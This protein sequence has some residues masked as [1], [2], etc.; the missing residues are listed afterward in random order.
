M[1]PAKGWIASM[2]YKVYKG[3]QSKRA[4]ANLLITSNQFMIASMSN[5]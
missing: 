1:V 3:L 4:T 2:V 5:M